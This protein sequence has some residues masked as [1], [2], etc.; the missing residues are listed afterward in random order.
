MSLTP[1]REEGSRRP[2]SK[3]PTAPRSAVA[4]CSLTRQHPARKRRLRGL[5]PTSSGGTPS[6]LRSISGSRGSTAVNRSRNTTTADS[7]GQSQPNETIDGRPT[8]ATNQS[9][10]QSA[11]GNRSSDGVDNVRFRNATVVDEPNEPN[12]VS[13]GTGSNTT[14]TAPANGSKPTVANESNVSIDNGSNVT[15]D[16]DSNAPVNNGSNISV[17]NGSNASVDN[18]S[19]I[20]VDNE[21]IPNGTTPRGKRLITVDIDPAPLPEG[22]DDTPPFAAVTVE[23][24]PSD[25][26]VVELLRTGAV[27][28][29]RGPLGTNILDQIDALAEGSVMASRSHAVYHLGYNTR[30]RPLRNPHFR[31]VIARLIDREAILTGVFD[32]NG[33]AVTDFL[34]AGRDESPWLPDELQ[35]DGEHPELPFFGADGSLDVRAAKAAFRELGYAYSTEGEL[36]DPQRSE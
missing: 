19:N 28:A 22:Y 29:T 10:A 14:A 34:S 33:A 8:N 5:N 21:S 3:P 26:T 13:N 32:D 25:N 17:D 23:V 31:R 12:T 2:R 35:W 27:D 1:R 7:D 16:N 24:A 4:P 9:I 30:S 6:R 20:P 15:V 18:G 11:T 36:I